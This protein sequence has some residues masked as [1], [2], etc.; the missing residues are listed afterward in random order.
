MMTRFARLDTPLAGLALIQRQPIGD[1]RGYLERLFC[2]D[3]LDELLQGRSIVQINHTYTAKA[4]TVRG[5]HF[6][7]PPHAEMKVVTCLRGEVFDVAVDLRQGSPTMLHWHAEHL[8][9]DNHRSLLI[10]EGFAH[11]FQTLTDDCELIYLHTAAYQPQAEVGLNPLDERLDI[12]WPLPFTEMSDRDRGHALISD[13]F[14]G[15]A[16]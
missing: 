16:S 10:P 6:Q 14:A 5:M 8:S 1:H 7:H 11:G 2:R 9:A 4:G 3:E 13:E 15:L 12:I